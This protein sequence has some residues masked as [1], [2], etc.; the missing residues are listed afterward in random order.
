[1]G[2]AA[3]NWFVANFEN[4]IRYPLGTFIMVSA[5]VALGWFVKGKTV[6]SEVAAS[7][8]VTEAAQAKVEA[9]ALRAD[10]QNAQASNAIAILP[11]AQARPS[12]PAGPVNHPT[13]APPLRGTTGALRVTAAK[14]NAQAQRVIKLFNRPGWHIQR[15]GHEP[16]GVPKGVTVMIDGPGL[17][18]ATQKL[19][20]ETLRANGLDPEVQPVSSD[21]MGIASYASSISAISG[22]LFERPVGERVSVTIL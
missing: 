7:K 21:S 9:A 6:Q 16:T 8:M 2:D 4:L 12:L 20:I 10:A 22:P 5:G 14:D 19:V 11:D 13:P 17:I 1:M 18:T 15:F 3:F